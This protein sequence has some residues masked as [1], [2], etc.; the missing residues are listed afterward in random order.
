MVFEDY[1]PFHVDNAD[2]RSNITWRWSKFSLHKTLST[3][4]PIPDLLIQLLTQSSQTFYFK[5]VK[6]L[7]KQNNLVY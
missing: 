1:L 7:E 4:N 5:R 2:A 3:Y 6:P